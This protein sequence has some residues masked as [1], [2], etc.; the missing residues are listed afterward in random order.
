MSGIGIGHVK[1]KLK[2][3]LNSEKSL[4]YFNNVTQ[5]LGNETIRGN[6]ISGKDG[7]NCFL[8]NIFCEKEVFVNKEQNNNNICDLI[9][10]GK[11][12][13]TRTMSLTG[14]GYFYFG[15]FGSISHEYFNINNFMEKSKERIN[16]IDYILLIVIDKSKP[17]ELFRVSYNF[18]LTS[19][20]NFVNNN[21]DIKYWRRKGGG[22][23]LYFNKDDFKEPIFTYSYSYK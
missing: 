20:K 5:P 15:C 4:K 10:Y 18:Y 11:K 6:V 21:G 13:I 2:S 12:I 22:M 8:I 23:F 19:V 17:N 1:E 9:I 14:N 16:N 7:V 3:I